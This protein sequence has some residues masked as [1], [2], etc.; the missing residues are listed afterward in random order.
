MGRWIYTWQ[1]EYYGENGII[2]SRIIDAKT[3]QDAL[4]ALRRSGELVIEVICCIRI[5]RW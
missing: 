1:I 5:D 4:D 2:R 3:K